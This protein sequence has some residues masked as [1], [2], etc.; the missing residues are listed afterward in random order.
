[1]ISI[2]G[3]SVDSGLFFFVQDVVKECLRL[4]DNVFDIDPDRLI[5]DHGDCPI[6]TVSDR[7]L[8][9]CVVGH[10]ATVLQDRERYVARIYT[11]SPCEQSPCGYT[12][13]N[14]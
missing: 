6:S 13:Q 7:D 11:K 1:M 3:K 5:R 4:F 14:E 10:N 12:A 2:Q 8:E 9:I